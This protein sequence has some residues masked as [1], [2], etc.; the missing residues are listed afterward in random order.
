MKLIVGVVFK[1]E[2]GDKDLKQKSLFIVLIKR[3]MLQTDSDLFLLNHL[4]IKSF[5]GIDKQMEHIGID[6]QMERSMFRL[7]FVISLTIR[8]DK[9][10][11]SKFSSYIESH[12]W[13]RKKKGKINPKA[14]MVDVSVWFCSHKAQNSNQKSSCTFIK[15]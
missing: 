10:N 12:T 13:L 6:K 2:G 11:E 5:I 8:C 3:I 1:Y 14:L 7:K 4:I 9:V 15:C